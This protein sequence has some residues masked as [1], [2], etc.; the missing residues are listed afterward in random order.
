MGH[1][2]LQLLSEG[3]AP[4]CLSQKA[5]GVVGFIITLIGGQGEFTV[6]VTTRITPSSQVH[7][8]FP[9][10]DLLWAVSRRDHLRLTPSW[11]WATV[12]SPR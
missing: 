4:T 6:H 9:Q 3:P 1:T 12:S 11:T 10:P 8:V 2:Q 5:S 7:S